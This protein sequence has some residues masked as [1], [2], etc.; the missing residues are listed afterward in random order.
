MLAS[1]IINI[2]IPITGYI[3]L[4]FKVVRERNYTEVGLPVTTY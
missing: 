3:D 4:N 2:D 1:I